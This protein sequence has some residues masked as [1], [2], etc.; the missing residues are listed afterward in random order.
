MQMSVGK[1]LYKLILCIYATRN[2]IAFLMHAALSLLYF[3]QNA[4][5]FKIFIFFCS[6]NIFFFSVLPPTPLFGTFFFTFLSYPLIEQPYL[7]PSFPNTL[8]PSAPIC[9]IT[10]FPTWLIL[11]PCR[12]RQQVPQKY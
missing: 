10:I 4:F 9:H 5:Y 12:W 11:V 8:I 6:N 1:H 2:F 3:P 7:R